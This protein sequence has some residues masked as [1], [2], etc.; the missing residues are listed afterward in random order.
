MHL[1]D[2]IKVL[3]E[4]YNSIDIRVFSYK[5]EGDW[6]N[7]FT[8][9]RFRR[10][11][12]DQ[13]ITNQTELIQRCGSLIETEKFKVGI[14]HY[15]VEKWTKIADELSQKFLCLSNSFAIHFDREITFNN[16]L[17]ESYFKSENYVYDDWKCFTS[18][19]ESNNSQKP[20]YVD[21][22]R[23]IA[24]ENNFSQFD[25]Y[26]SA[27]FEYNKYD[28]QSNP[29]VK[30]FIPV[31]FKIEKIEFEHDKAIV[32]YSAYKQKH[33]KVA[34]NFYKSRAYRTHDKFVEKK[35]KELQLTGDSE[36]IH[37]KII[38]EIDTKNVGNSFE[39]LVIKNKNNLIENEEG[40]VNE[41]WKERTEYTNPLY[42]TFEQFVKFDE[43]EQMLL[44]FKSKKIRKESDVFERG[45]AWLLSLLGIPNIMLGEYEQMGNG[46]E[47]TSTDILG[48]FHSDRVLLINA[49]TGLPQQSDFDRER[50]YRENIEINLTN[51]EL[52]IHSVYFTGKDATESEHSATI[53]NVRLIGKSSIKKILEYLKKGELED[54]RNIIFG[55]SN[56]SVGL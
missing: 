6:K 52:K 31:F 56:S 30:I 32:E 8:I 7:I 10:E 5:S 51:K 27:I 34:L 12:E 48:S 15:P 40:L 25:H 42:Y 53:N 24:L 50:Q 33:I 35:V 55:T 29:W 38:M 21:E 11:S 26:L 2:A 36:I 3:Q 14:F 44:Q 19:N 1:H 23:S 28:F 54:A 18:N 49:T 4:N 46:Y 13:L 22:L 47:Q 20:N 9:I 45:I 41:Y 37:D 17:S 43:L 39:L 16:T